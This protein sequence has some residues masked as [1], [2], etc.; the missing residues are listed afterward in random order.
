[1]T[2]VV[3]RPLVKVVAQGAVSQSV[4]V[5]AGASAP[6]SL[7]SSAVPRWIL[8]A[9]VAVGV[10]LR[11]WR[12]GVNGLTF[13]ETFTAMAGRR[14]V[15]DLL[16]FLRSA[17]SH[18]PLD[19]LLRMPLAR[20]E[21]SDFVFRSPSVVASACALGLFAWWVRKRGW[22]GVVATALMAV[23][24]F[25]LVYGGEARM[26][27]L[28]QLLGV[29]VAMLALEWLRR[30]RDWH[31]WAVGGLLL[32]AAFD[33]V[34]A[35]LLAAGVFL[36]PWTRRDPVALRWR[37]G[38]A[39]PV[40]VW[41]IVWGPAMVEQRSGN[42]AS[43]I[44]L[45]TP[46]GFADVV[47]RHVTYTEW[48]KPLAFLAVV[49]GGLVLVRADRLLGRVFV[50]CAVV[51]FV[52]AAVVGVF[53]PFFFDRTLT[54]SSWAAPLAV[55]FLVEWV[56]ERYRTIG[57]AFGALVV[58]L[59]LMSSIW[60]FGLPWDTDLSM[61]HLEAVAQPGDVL[62]VYPARQADIV[63]W[64]IGVRGPR[65]ARAVSVRGLPDTEAIELEGAA[66]TGR[67]WLLAWAWDR[68][69]F[70]RF[71]RCAPEWSDGTTKVLCLRARSVRPATEPAM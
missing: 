11:V 43:W 35:L 4:R 6:S 37:F 44:P 70:P 63:E 14:S 40:V 59:A 13:D 30:P 22:L 49:G 33:H 62:A 8:P 58:V 25:Q 54:L 31:A 20:A 66:T 42:F 29:G 39:I 15:G 64:R 10:L 18:P 36:L 2:G 5:I 24:T 12:A 46:G 17:D 23:S 32:V 7:R 9:L 69:R 53:V 45:T 34:S 56:R 3:H 41:T 71:E 38:A 60:F 52:L 48:T 16:A 19:Y 68:H 50:C 51:P 26:Y 1:M 57:I 47:A 65:P 21:V 28:L 55:A 61:Q 67:V 27:A